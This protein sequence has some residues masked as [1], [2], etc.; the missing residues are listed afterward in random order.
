MNNNLTSLDGAISKF[1]TRLKNEN[2]SSNTIIAYENDLKQLVEFI[3]QDNV[4]NANQIG[5]DHIKNFKNYLLKEKKYTNKTVSRKLNSI[6]S[7]FRF[8]TASG[9]ISQDP[10]NNITHPKISQKPP[11]ILSPLEYRAL[12]DVCRDD[13]RSY[14]II[15]LMLQ[16]GLRISEAANLEVTDIQEDKIIVRPYESHGG[17]VIPLNRAAKKAIEDYLEERPKTKKSTNL[18][19]TKNGNPLLVRNIRNSINRYF[20]IAEIADVYV[21]NLRDTF[22]VQQLKAGVPLNIV[23]QIIGHKRVSSTEKYLEL[24]EERETDNIKLKEL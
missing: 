22:V 1:L 19:I 5:T 9:V 24:V 14:A 13:P 18:F 21:N 23:S 15:E 6:K 17:R 2:R 11:R 3:G 4:V 7:L 10:A 8:L 20:K 12:R 16:A